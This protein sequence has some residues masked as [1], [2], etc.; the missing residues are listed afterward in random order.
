[1][2]EVTE[3][4]V[5]VYYDQESLE[6]AKTT[7]DSMRDRFGVEMGRMH[8]K[9]VGPHPCWSCQMRVPSEKIGPVMVW[10]CTNRAGLTIFCHPET[11]NSLADHADHAIWMGQMLDLDLSIFDT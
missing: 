2:P 5:H 8:E 6:L 3:F 10:L 4:H 1:M 11:G 9:P 7:C